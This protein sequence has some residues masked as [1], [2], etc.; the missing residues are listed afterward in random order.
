MPRSPLPVLPLDDT[1]RDG[2]RRVVTNGAHFAIA[3]FLDGVWTFDSGAPLDFVPV[4]YYAPT[5][6][7]R[8]H[9]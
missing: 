6:G 5:G 1:A 9:G 7:E 8:A 4:G 3:R 2:R